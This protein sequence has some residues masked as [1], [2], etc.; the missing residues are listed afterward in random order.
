MNPWI[1][2][3]KTDRVIILRIRADSFVRSDY[4][5][6][7]YKKYFF[8]ARAQYIIRQDFDDSN[9]SRLLKNLFIIY[10]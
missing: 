2:I 9:N 4:F 3:Y 10:D 7:E 6:N 1:S 8:F 5:I